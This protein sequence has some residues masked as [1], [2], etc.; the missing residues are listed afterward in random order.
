M[1]RLPLTAAAAVFLVMPA[2]AWAAE[3]AAATPAVSNAD[4]AG[5]YVGVGVGY[6]YGKVKVTDLD[7]YNGPPPIIYQPNGM[8]AVGHGGYNWIFD[9]G[10]VLGVEGELGWFGFEGDAQY[11]PYVGVRGVNDSRAA[12]EGRF[13]LTVSGRVGY[14]VGPWLL[15]GKGGLAAS[16]IQ[17]SYIDT[18]P[19]GTTLVTGTATSAFRTGY[20]AGG[21]LEFMFPSGQMSARIEY[22]HYDLGDMT[23]AA[24]SA[25]GSVW[26]FRHAMTSNVVK[27]ALTWHLGE[28]PF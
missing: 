1:T 28:S 11:P 10:W 26:H 24:R 8:N 20:A 9:P 5:F 27:F 19:S 23:Q 13:L 2:A 7:S 25:G 14:A 3:D 15:Y 18:D 6:D 12:I 16:D 21:G 17:A 4:W 22:D